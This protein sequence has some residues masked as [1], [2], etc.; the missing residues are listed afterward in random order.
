[1]RDVVKF[2]LKN[3]ESQYIFRYLYRPRLGEGHWLGVVK[4][5]L[6]R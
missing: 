4:I 6:V 2:G 3:I 1:M 5:P